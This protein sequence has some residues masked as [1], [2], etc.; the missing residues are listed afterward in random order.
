MANSLISFLIWLG[1]QNVA[2]ILLVLP[3]LAWLDRDRR[4]VPTR[5]AS[6]LVVEFWGQRAV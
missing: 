1:T 6:T 4:Q 5:S 3:C 2:S